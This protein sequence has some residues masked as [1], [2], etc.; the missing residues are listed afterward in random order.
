MPT[1][2]LWIFN[3]QIPNSN[4]LILP[5]GYRVVAQDVFW[6]TRHKALTLRTNKV[7]GASAGIVLN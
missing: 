5:R 7:D 1:L 6:K 3:V 2:F 4:F